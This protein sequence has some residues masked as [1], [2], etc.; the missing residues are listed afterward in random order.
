LGI[1]PR[2]NDRA[3]EVK[4]LIDAF[5]YIIVA[6]WYEILLSKVSLPWPNAL[7]NSDK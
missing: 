7:I 5:W 3:P 2:R 6:F 1:L 4:P